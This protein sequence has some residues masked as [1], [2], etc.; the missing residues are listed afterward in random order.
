MLPPVGAGTLTKVL[1][2]PGTG[3]A[4][5][6]VGAAVA[7]AG[8]DEAGTVRVTVVGAGPQAVQTVVLV[9]KPGAMPEVTSSGQ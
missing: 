7:V 8:T 4:E 9:V 2:E 1:G 6:E 3:L 5:K